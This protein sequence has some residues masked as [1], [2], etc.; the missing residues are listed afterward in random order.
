MASQSPVWANENMLEPTTSVAVHHQYLNASNATS[1][2]VGLLQKKPAV[3]W[4]YYDLDLANY[5]AAISA[6]NGT[7]YSAYNYW[8]PLAAQAQTYQQSVASHF[9]P[10][11]DLFADVRNGSLPNVSW[12]I[13]GGYSDH[14]PDNLSRGEA[15]IA[16]IVDAVESGPEWNSTALFISWDDFGGYYDNVRPPVVDGY[17]YGFRV[18]LIVVSPYARE[19]YVN[20]VN[21]SFDSILYFIEHRY[22]LGCLTTRDCHSAFPMGFFNFTNPPRAPVAFST[23]YT[24]WRYPM[25]LQGLGAPLAA[26]SGAFYP[27]ADV[28]STANDTEED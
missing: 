14:P 15:T 23:V 25:P 13:P 5:S 10:R 4:K 24:A 19:N 26:P 22:G 6:F 16:S 21:A 20:H 9:V 7:G 17:G 12:W 18:P 1:T 8:N 11:A 28:L 27:S 2:V 3:T